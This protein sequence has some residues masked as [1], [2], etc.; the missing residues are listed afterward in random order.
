MTGGKE[1]CVPTLLP[2]RSLPTDER[3]CEKAMFEPASWKYIAL[4]NYLQQQLTV[5]AGK[6]GGIGRIRGYAIR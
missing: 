4:N 6:S 5:G 1:C 2:K 3:I